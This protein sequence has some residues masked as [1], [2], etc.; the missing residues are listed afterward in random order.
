MA[1][2]NSSLNCFA[3]CMVKYRLSYIDKIQ[4]DKPNSNF[5]FGTMAHK[6]LY[7]AG[8]LRDDVLDGVVSD[9]EYR[10][11]IP[12]EVLYNNLKEEFKINNWEEYFIPIIKQVYEYE[13]KCRC[14]LR[15]KIKI[16]RELKLQLSPEEMHKVGLLKQPFVGVIDL[17]MISNNNQAVILD[18]KFSNHRKSIDD[19]NLNSQLQLYAYFVNKIYNIP[20]RDIWIGY[21]DIPKMMFDKPILLSNNTLSRSKSQ[22]VLQE[23]YKRRVIEIHGENNP[24]YNCEEGGY[25]YDCY[26]NLALN[27]VA[28]LSLLPVDEEICY[29]VI[30]D[31]IATG[32]MIDKMTDMKLPYLRKY[33]SYSC[34]SCEYLSKC[35]PY[36]Y[37]KGGE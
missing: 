26:C 25:Y 32:I 18:Y 37:M 28:Y 12:S 17:L 34:K 30:G 31:L 9:D 13:K 14:M 15:G 35:K 8:I 7:D 27:K 2:S 6:V 1:H 11:I 10:Q 3:N 19:F 29:N 5:E 4:P 23:E 21:I 24:K 22:N 33:D 20:L 16:K 36:L